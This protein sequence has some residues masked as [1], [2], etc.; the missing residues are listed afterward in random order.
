MCL[1]PITIVPRYRELNWLGSSYYQQV[2]CLDCPEC[3]K[4]KASDFICRYY[5]DAQYTQECG[6]FVYLDTLTWN[7]KQVH[8]H[9]KI[10]HFS[11]DDVRR[12]K[13]LFQKKAIDLIL[14]HFGWSR[15]HWNIDKA[16]ALYRRD[17]K[18]LLVEEYG[19]DYHRPHIHLSIFN[20]ISF[21]SPVDIENLVIASWVIENGVRLGG[22][23]KKNAYLKLIKNAVAAAVYVS[24]YLCK[25]D[26]YY[27]TVQKRASDIV[28]KFGIT[29]KI[30]ERFNQLLSSAYKPRNYFYQGFG[31]S[32]EK[33]YSPSDL[34]AHDKIIIPDSFKVKKEV[35]IPLYTIRRVFKTRVQREDR[36]YKE[37]WNNLGINYCIKYERKRFDSLT[38]FYQS[39]IDSVDTYS[40]FLN[41]D[42]KANN[43]VQITDYYRGRVSGILGNRRLSD[44]V[45]YKMYYKGKLADSL[46]DVVLHGAVRKD[47][48]QP[49]YPFEYRVQQLHRRTWDMFEDSRLKCD[50]RCY[51]EYVISEYCNPL[52]HGFDK[53]DSL[54]ESLLSSFNAHT[55]EFR[56]KDIE[57]KN[58]YRRLYKSRLHS[59]GLK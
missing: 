20:R 7:E 55:V 14:L 32:I 50:I 54:F 12:F 41:Y 49:C 33:I 28:R 46:R 10:R 34:L 35:R 58:R 37:I 6:G 57:S 31:A 40:E 38:R 27:K 47:N 45:L 48:F 30:Y 36:T 24:G 44:F 16:K 52:W 5:Y 25:E 21:L 43:N 39:L 2:P 4:Q 13:K 9:F 8:K 23:E 11:S 56:Q 3:R 18:L 17:C 53:L 1:S 42:E 59:C 26:D 29:S 22:I 15:S 51:R 19:G